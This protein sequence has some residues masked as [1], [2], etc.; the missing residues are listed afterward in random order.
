[1]APRR[2]FGAHG[3]ATALEHSPAEGDLAGAAHAATQAIRDTEK[4]DDPSAA[5]EAHLAAAHVEAALGHADHVRRHA[6]AAQAAARRARVPALRSGRPPKGACLEQCG[7]P[8]S[9]GAR[10][11]LLRAATRL[12]PLAAARVRSA[13]RRPEEEDEELRRFVDFSGAVALVAPPND[14]SDLIRRFQTLLDAIHDTPDESAALGVIAGDVLTTLDACSVVIRSARL[15]RQAAAAGR[16]WPGEEALTQPVLDGG[17]SMFRDGGATPEAA[18]PVRAA[19][20]VVGSI[21]VRWV[22]GRTPPLLRTK[23]QLRVAAAAAAPLLRAL[24]AV[25]PAPADAAVHYPDDLLGRG[26]AADRVRDAIRRAALA[27]YPVLIEGES[28]SGKEL[29]AR[30]IHARGPRRRM[31]VLR[32]E[33]RG[34]ER[35]SPRG[36]ALRPR[37]R[38]VHGRG[39]GRPGLFEEADQGAILLDEAGSWPRAQAAARAAGREV[40]RVGE[41]LPRKVDARVVAATS[42]S[43]EEDVRADRFAPT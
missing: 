8:S 34:A 29:V 38:R 30:A 42:R 40:R 16:A 14:N 1:M 15:A 23:E 7:I 3:F 32:G 39:G 26:L 37:T 35:R 21:A 31:P 19:G 22:T 5:C 13:L 11:R 6:N 2:H 9:G 25:Q 33:L 28:G 43:L 17:C 27:P 24:S 4:R 10:D 20:S 41:N 12:P 18:E 36:R